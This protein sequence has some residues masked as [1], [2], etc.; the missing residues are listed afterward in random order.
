VAETIPLDPRTLEP[1]GQD[2]ARWE[3]LVDRVADGDVVYLGEANHFV[4]E[5]VEFRCWWLRRLAAR[6]PLI[7]GEE[8][9]WSDSR[10]VAAFLA[11]GDAAHLDRAATFGDGRHIR[12]DRDDTT[13]TKD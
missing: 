7:V 4:H 12:G 11:T 5:K 9:S 2:R 6:R 3:E 8:L 1:A 10:R 13:T